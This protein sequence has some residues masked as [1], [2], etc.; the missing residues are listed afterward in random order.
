MAVIIYMFNFKI[1]EMEK[2]FIQSVAELCRVEVDAIEHL[3]QERLVQDYILPKAVME[4]SQYIRGWRIH[5]DF[6]AFMAQWGQECVQRDRRTGEILMEI[7]MQ[8]VSCGAVVYAFHESYHYLKALPEEYHKYSVINDQ[9]GLMD[10]ECW[11]FLK[12]NLLF[13]ATK[14]Q[15]GVS[16]RQAELICIGLIVGIH[17]DATISFL[18][19]KEIVDDSPKQVY[20]FALEIACKLFGI[21]E[22]ASLFMKYGWQYHKDFFQQHAGEIDFSKLLENMAYEK[23]GHKYFGKIRR[24][25]LK[26]RGLYESEVKNA[27]IKE[28]LA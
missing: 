22:V 25:Y 24:F 1:N 26:L 20:Q 13:C 5:S 27:F 18:W 10:Q 7:A 6:M 19:N 14:L 16:R 8:R 17:S 12:Q 11:D 3:S 9:S 15:N 28:I 4:T 23:T 2:N 21:Q